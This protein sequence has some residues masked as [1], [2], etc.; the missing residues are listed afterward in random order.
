MLG[1][2]AGHPRHL[3][4]RH[5]R[6]PGPG[7]H[8]RPRP[9]APGLHRRQRPRHLRRH[10]PRLRRG[11]RLPPR[12]GLAGTL[13]RNPSRAGREDPAHAGGHTLEHPARTAA[14]VSAGPGLRSGAETRPDARLRLFPAGNPRRIRLGR[15]SLGPDRHGDRPEPL[16]RRCCGRRERHLDFTCTC[17]AWKPDANCKHVVCAA[18]T[19]KNLLNPGSFM[20]QGWDA[21]KREALLRQIESGG[22]AAPRRPTAARERVARRKRL[23]RRP[24]ADA[25][26]DF[27]IAIVPGDR[28]PTSCSAR[29]PAG[30]GAPRLRG[31]PAG[32]ARSALAVPAARPVRQAAA[33]RAVS[34]EPRRRTPAA[35]ADPG[36]SAGAALSPRAGRCRPHRTRRPARGRPR[37][38]SL[39]ARGKRAAGRADRRRPRARRRGRRHF[40][41]DRPARL[42]DLERDRRRAPA[43]RPEDEPLL[44]ERGRSRTTSRRATRNSP[45]PRWPNC[46]AGS[47]SITRR[48]RARRRRP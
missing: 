34:R 47:R 26:A 21:G 6:P 3:R 14:G 12:P 38:E 42:A 45:R 39:P 25:A 7:D 5:P 30:A 24:D 15:R 22:G 35:A 43:P 33:A 41:G 1:G 9:R 13:K 27:A 2:L 10:G 8:P 46:S 44:P 11:G 28:S 32:A 18:L 31:L 29:R 20:V 36:G 19:I 17:P 4:R 40:G 16:P 23:R 48:T 37:R